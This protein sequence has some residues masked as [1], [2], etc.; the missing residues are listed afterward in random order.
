MTPVNYAQLWQLALPQVIVVVAALIALG[1]RSP[2]A[3]RA[4]H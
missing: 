4:A 3:A 1:G 2:A